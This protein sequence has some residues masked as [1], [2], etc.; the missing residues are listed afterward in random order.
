MDLNRIQRP[1]GDD[2]VAT[3]TPPSVQVKNDEGLHLRIDLRFIL[4]LIVLLL[5]SGLASLPDGRDYLR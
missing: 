2:M 4:H 3:N 1:C 5:N